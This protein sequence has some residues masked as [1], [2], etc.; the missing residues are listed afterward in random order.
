MSGLVV[1]STEADATLVSCTEAIH[2]MKWSPRRT[3]AATTS[4]TSRRV[5]ARISLRARMTTAGARSSDTK[6]VRHAAMAN[7]GAS[8][9]RRIRMGE[10]PSAISPSV[11]NTHTEAGARP[12]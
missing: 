7:A 9:A 4:A 1:T 8:P 6:V 11:R 12:T 10:A 2:A 5:N 3:P